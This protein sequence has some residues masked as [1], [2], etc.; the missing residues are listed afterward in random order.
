MT[1]HGF[2]FVTGICLL[3]A[4]SASHANAADQ[5]ISG[6][7]LL[8]KSSPKM[9]LLSKDALVIAGANGSSSDP[10]CLGDGGGGLGGSITLDDG[11]NSA[12]LPMPCANW[13]TNGSGTL[14][15]FKDPAGAPKV[16]K[17]KGGL[18]KIV[19]PGLGGFPVP[20][21]AATID[22]QVQIGSDSYCMTFTGTGNGNKFLV[23]DAVAGACLLPS[24][25]PTDTPTPTP[26]PTDTPTFGTL[27]YADVQPVFLTKCSPCHATF[28]S[29]G[30]NFAASYADS[31]L[32]S[33]YCP[34]Q[35]K[36]YCTLVRVQNG[37]MPAGGG[38]TGNPVLDV[39]N[40]A[41]LTASEQNLLSQWITQGQQP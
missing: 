31:Q 14:Y 21:G 41:C 3:A 9:V 4:L 11:T 38:C 25:T 33:Y 30:T 39:G 29:G 5:A 23:K 40:S 17:V 7:K 22:V 8:L 13:T 35:T 28:G 36:G 16:A 6:K 37:S 18:L 20:N 27:T 10:R 12:T 2:R 32:P 34:G 26:T 19:S 24:A 1:P 15:K